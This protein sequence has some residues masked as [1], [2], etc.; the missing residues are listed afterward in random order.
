MRPIAALTIAIAVF[1]MAPHPHAFAARRTKA[2]SSKIQPRDLVDI[3]HAP[4]EELKKL[5]GIQDALAAKIIRNRPYANK[6]Q[7]S[8]K[9]IVS[10]AAYRQIRR[11][12]IAK[13]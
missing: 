8:S 4:V 9:G 10:A 5:P 1:L 6:T 7:L 11:L 13:Q 3:N 2:T 12:I